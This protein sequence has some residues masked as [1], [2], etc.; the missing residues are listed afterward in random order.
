MATLRITSD[1]DPYPIKAGLNMV[2]DGSTSRQFPSGIIIDQSHDFTFTYRGGSNTR[3]PESVKINKPIGIT[4][5]GVLI[6]S[7]ASTTRSLS[8]TQKSA[9]TNFTWNE[10]ELPLDFIVD[11]CG[12]KPDTSGQYTY[13]SS[14][15]YSKGMINNQTF[16]NS[17]VY[18]NSA[19]NFGSDKLRHGGAIPGSGT[20]I[21]PGHSKII[22]FAFDGYPIYGPYGFTNP[23]DENSPVTRMRSSYQKLSTPSAGRVYDYSEVPAGAFVEDYVY[24]S[25]S[26]TGTLDEFNGRFCKTPDFMSGTYAYFLTFE[27][28]NLNI[29][30]YPYIIG[31]S[32]RE[33]RTV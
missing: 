6:F 17:N 4:T 1:G 22:G 29:P 28:S 33:Q 30:E 27:D 3:D 5:N 10:V 14:S 25:L 7:P 31:P 24:N 19:N 23:D 8:T 11:A 26:S 9:P 32:T 18:Y 13:R 15:F 21:E 20:S 12:G 2:N 16:F